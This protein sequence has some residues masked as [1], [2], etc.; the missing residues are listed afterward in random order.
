MNP[1]SAPLLELTFPWLSPSRTVVITPLPEDLRNCDTGAESDGLAI[2]LDFEDTHLSNFGTR[3]LC[4]NIPNSARQT[5]HG[6]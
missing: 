5:C 3:R 1:V 4:Q 2:G 6:C